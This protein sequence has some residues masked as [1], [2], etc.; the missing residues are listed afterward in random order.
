MKKIFTTLFVTLLTTCAFAATEQAWYNDV[1]SISNNGQYYIYSVNGKGFMQAGQGKVKS[2]TTS[3]YTNVADFKFTITKAEK[4]N[5]KSGSKYLKSYMVLTGSSGSGPVCDN[6]SDDGTTIIWTSMDNG[7]YW[8]IHGFYHAWTKDRYPALRYQNNT[9]DGH[10]SGSGINYSSTKDLQTGTEY[11]WYLISQAQL[12]RHFAIYFFDAFKETL[13]DYTKFN[14]TVPAAYYTALQAAYNKTFSVTDASVTTA[15]VDAAKTTL[16]NLYNNAPAMA[17]AYASAKSVI[18]ALDGLKDK[19]EGD[20]TKIYAD[21]ATAREAIEQATTVEALTTAVSAP[22]L[23]G[24]DPITFTVTTFKALESIGNPAATTNGRSITYEAADKKII[25]AAGKAL[26]KG[27]TILTATAA[28]NNDYY[29]FVRKA[30]VVVMPINNT[31]TFSTSICQGESYAFQGET[32]TE[33]TVKDFTLVNRTG[34]DSVVTFT[35]TINPTYEIAETLS[36]CKGTSIVWRNK[37]L[38]K[39]GTYYDSLT[40]ASGCDSVYVL[41]LTEDPTYEIAEALSFCKGTSIVWRNKT[42]DKAGTYYDSLTTFKGCDSVYVLTLTENPTY[43]IAESEQACDTYTWRGKT[44]TTSGVYYDSL[45]TVNGCDSVYVLTL[46]ITNSI[47]TNDGAAIC[48]SELP[49]QWNDIVFTEAG[50]K[51]ATFTAVAGCDSTVTFTLTVLPEYT[52]AES[53]TM[54]TGAAETWHNRDLSKYAIGEY[55][56]Y[57]SLK[58]VAGC[59]SVYVLTLTVNEAPVTY[60]EESGS[61]CGEDMFTYYDMQYAGGT[62]NVT[63]KNANIYGGDSIVTLTVTAYQTYSVSVD[64]TACESYE[65][66]GKKLTNSGVYHETLST[67]NG[68]DST[69]TL[70]LTIIHGVTGTDNIVLCASDLPYNWNGEIF[71]ESG[72][73]T[74]TFTAA[75]GCDSVVTMTVEVVRCKQTVTWLTEEQTL[76]VGDS[77]T[78]EAEATSLEPVIYDLDDPT[79]A[80]ITDDNVLV[81]MSAGQVTVTATQRGTYYWESAAADLVITIE[82]TTALDIVPADVEGTRKFIRN[83]QLYIIRNGEI[84]NALGKRIE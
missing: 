36:F 68:C 82:P 53:K 73:K 30:E 9:Y 4:G 26:Y 15:V 57:D 11:R 40:T 1:T 54:M 18:N 20:L 38:D 78:L 48:Q 62:Y 5:V 42:L 41:T 22:A 77:L 44:L 84:Y 17:E 7:S 27:T 19:G 34:G 12:D 79:L 31:G 33:A 70:N 66:F 76:T 75:N 8:N 83:G 16:E 3:N 13:A 14:G 32:F 69:I 71:T 39:A 55:T 51:E 10:M 52:I 63:L 2:I 61:F 65:W 25:N 74:H 56:L 29:T 37:T 50:S 80:I 49:Y 43:E 47:R 28:E 72:V 64:E 67:I 58:T 46:T 45:T 24:I 6:N 23:K 59:D 21:I 35:L 60:G 81:A